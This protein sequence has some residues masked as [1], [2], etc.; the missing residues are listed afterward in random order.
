MSKYKKVIF[1]CTGNTC[2]SPM[3]EAIFRNLDRDSDIK[4]SSRGLVVLFGEPINPKAEI[5]LKN[6]NLELVNHRAK[7]LKESEI[8]ENT[9]VLTMTQDQKRK[10]LQNYPG[11]V[12]V[13]SIK[14]FA[15]ETG[16]V[17]DPYGGTLV[18]Y[19]ECFK[20]LAILVKKTVYKINEQ[21]QKEDTL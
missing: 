11:A 9:L 13:Y 8:D 21:N 6:H 15:G 7:G 18:D 19:E 16:D 4:V 10:V 3:A 17:V 1:V 2:R 20:E 12:N 5:V 14:E